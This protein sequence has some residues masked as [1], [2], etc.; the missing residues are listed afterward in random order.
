M[1]GLKFVIGELSN[2]SIVFVASFLTGSFELL[3]ASSSNNESNDCL[4][5]TL[6]SINLDSKIDFQQSLNIIFALVS[7]FSKVNPF[8]LSVNVSGVKA[9]GFNILSM[10]YL[11]FASSNCEVFR[12]L[13][14]MKFSNSFNTLMNNKLVSSE[15]DEN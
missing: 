6:I 5:I 8:D 10:G 4:I 15:A 1:N 9:Y 7:Q 13:G 14:D 3:A 2:E 12:I 11:I